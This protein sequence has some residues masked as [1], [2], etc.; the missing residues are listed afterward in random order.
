MRLEQ[1][2]G[3]RVPLIQAPMAGVQDS[4]L[5]L[6]VGA[7]GAL[8]S[9]P[10]AMMDTQRLARELRALADSGL[11]YNANFFCH[12]PPV[13]D[14]A[15]EA[16]WRGT[17]APYYREL[18]VP[19]DAAGGGRRPFDAE[20]AEVLED[21]RPTVVSFHF[22][23]PA[24]DLLARV[25]ARGA[26]VASSATTL[27]EAL[28]LQEN[29]ADAIIAQGLEAGGHRGHFLDRDPARQSGTLALLSQLGGRVSL[30]VIAAGGIADAGDVRAALA[31]GAS[32]VQVGTAFLLCD[33]ATTG[34]LH[35]AR[36]QD[37]AAPTALTNLFSGGLARGLYNRAMRELGAVNPKAPP[38]PLA[39]AAMAPLRTQAEAVGRDD[40]TPLWSGTNRKG[41]RTGP[42]AAV[43][44]AL[45]AGWTAAG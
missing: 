1:L 17:L 10:A 27:R 39:S 11:P 31:A 22:G 9:L 43:V 42:A 45:A 21:F 5:A 7:A 34:P 25:K 3:T 37:L 16:A 32:A 35:R 15:V 8:G 29:G 13:P 26:M 38:F 40:F 30:P 20:A 44:Q 41:C 6:A 2:W 33:E 28:W 24:A 23:L 14:A 18:D 4:R 36:L 12:V 19:L